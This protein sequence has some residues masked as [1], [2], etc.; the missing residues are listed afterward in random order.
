M[1]AKA[2]QYEQKQ[3]GKLTMLDVRS[4]SEKTQL[5]VF[6][7]L[8]EESYKEAMA[9]STKV[10]IY[11]NSIRITKVEKCSKTKFLYMFSNFKEL[12]KIALLVPARY[13]KVKL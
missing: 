8:C 3:G 1:K 2:N 7:L 6:K 5:I 12:S 13:K 4:E 9:H 11:A 10:Y